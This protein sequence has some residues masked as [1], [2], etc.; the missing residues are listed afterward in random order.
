[1]VFCLKTK[2]CG[3]VV[4]GR[5]KIRVTNKAVLTFEHPKSVARA[6]ALQAP[7]AVMAAKAVN[8]KLFKN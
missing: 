1:M 5:Q 2:C 4:H 8:L 3:V 6:W 7:P